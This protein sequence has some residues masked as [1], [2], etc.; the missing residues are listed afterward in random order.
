MMGI[1]LTAMAV[2]MVLAAG[3][4]LWIVFSEGEER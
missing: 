3:C 4:N 1:F 2:M